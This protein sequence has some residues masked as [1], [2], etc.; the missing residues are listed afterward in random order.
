M[1]PDLFFVPF[2]T[3]A[4]VAS[5]SRSPYSPPHLGLDSG[6]VTE[7]WELRGRRPETGSWVVTFF[8]ENL[9]P[10][11]SRKR[12]KTQL[13]QWRVG[14]RGLWHFSWLFWYFVHLAFTGEWWC[15]G[16]RGTVLNNT[17]PPTTLRF[18]PICES[19][20][21]AWGCL[22][23]PLRPLWSSGECRADAMTPLQLG[24][25]RDGWLY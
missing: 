25:S 10:G 20:F 7:G 6:W 2:L 4:P 24:I 13:W 15:E 19:T 9:H 12:L 14:R 5:T 18:S 1:G 8:N 23:E 17:N 16:E 21:L 3:S 11:F 22:G